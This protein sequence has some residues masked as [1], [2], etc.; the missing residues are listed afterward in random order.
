MLRVRAPAELI[1]GLRLEAQQPSCWRIW[2][3]PAQTVQQR[4][5]CAVCARVACS[6]RLR[7]LRPVW[8]AAIAASRAPHGHT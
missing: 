2:A 8:A 5:R 1:C 7:Y 6:A 3:L 4:L